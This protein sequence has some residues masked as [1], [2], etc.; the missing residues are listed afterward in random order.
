MK[1]DE[2]WLGVIVYALI[3]A[4]GFSRPILKKLGNIPW[5]RPV[6]SWVQGYFHP[7]SPEALKS[8]QA[9]SRTVQVH[10]GKAS[11]A[12]PLPAALA[13]DPLRQAR[14]ENWKRLASHPAGFNP[15]PGSA[16]NEPSLIRVK[17]LL[18]LKPA[19]PKRKAISGEEPTKG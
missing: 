6:R 19:V 8:A 2:F 12:V 3:I 5:D 10:P 11:A 18:K 4:A 15:E 14:E 9:H 7:P 1:R 16:V 13:A 17:A